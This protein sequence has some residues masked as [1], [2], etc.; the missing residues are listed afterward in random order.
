[1][2]ASALLLST[3]KGEAARVPLAAA[4]VSSRHVMVKRKQVF[5]L[6]WLLP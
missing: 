6:Q 4:A 1:L 5:M 2:V 3:V